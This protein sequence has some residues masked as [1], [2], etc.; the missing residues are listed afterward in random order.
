V[1]VSPVLKTDRNIPVINPKT[2]NNPRKIKPIMA[3]NMVHFL[4]ELRFLR[5][6]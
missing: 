4:V 5:V 1:P 2:I 3:R 6:L